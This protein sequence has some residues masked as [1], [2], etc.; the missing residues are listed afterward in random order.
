[1]A[2]LVVIC[3]RPSQIVHEQTPWMIVSSG[4]VTITMVQRWSGS[5]G[6]TSSIPSA[7]AT[8]AQYLLPID[9]STAG[10]HEPGAYDV[11]IAGP[12]GSVTLGL[13]IV[14]QNITKETGSPVLWDDLPCEDSYFAEQILTTDLPRDEMWSMARYRIAKS[15]D[16]SGSCQ[17]QPQA[18]LCANLFGGG[19]RVRVFQPAPGTGEW[20]C[21]AED[22]VTGQNSVRTCGSDGWTMEA[23]KS[24]PFPTVADIEF[25]CTST[26]GLWR[27]IYQ[28]EVAGWALNTISGSTGVGVGNYG[29]VRLDWQQSTSSPQGTECEEGGYSGVP[30]VSDDADGGG[31]GGPGDDSPP[32]SPPASSQPFANGLT[33]GQGVLDMPTSIETPDEIFW[34]IKYPSGFGS[35]VGGSAASWNSITWSSVN[36]RVWPLPWTHLMEL[37]EAGP[38]NSVK[39]IFET[40]VIVVRSGLQIALV[41]MF[42]LAVWKHLG[43]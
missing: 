13:F 25:R 41:V 17:G 2:E 14:T 29:I 33:V 1:M 21:V 35:G 6:Y 38:I 7:S 37:G 26:G 22:T 28:C 9:Y 32:E 43:R 40:A 42:L 24:T 27:C 5:T 16:G 3:P 20:F 34:T 12:D 23:M 8:G 39:V 18:D 11:T 31:S 36:F 4:D 30:G 15:F 19:W 10:M